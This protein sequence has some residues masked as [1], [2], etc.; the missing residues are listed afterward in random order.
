MSPM[1]LLYLIGEAGSDDSSI[2]L[3]K[4]SCRASRLAT[5]SGERLKVAFDS[6]ASLLEFDIVD[7]IHRYVVSSINQ[8]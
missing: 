5:S 8:V 1:K 7:P 4:S 6:A 2:K 3:N